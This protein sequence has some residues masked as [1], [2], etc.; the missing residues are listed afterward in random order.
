MLDLSL[1]LPSLLPDR[2][3]R[4]PRWEYKCEFRE[5]ES[6][7]VGRD[8]WKLERRQHFEEQGS[9][10]RDAFRRGDWAEALRLLEARGAALR[11][12]VEGE[13]RRRSFFHRVRVVEEP[14]TPYLQWELHSQRQ[15]AEYGERIHVVDAAHVRAAE[16]AAPLPEVV[17]LGGS[18]LYTVVYSASGAPEGAVR[19]TDPALVRP[20]EVFLRRLYAEGEDVRSYFDRKVASL[21]PPVAREQTISAE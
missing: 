5:R 4:L 11:A 15:R 1:S 20:W 8:S 19:F 13:R 12:S 16:T 3:V 14:L 2:G 18:H 17:I 21:R 6:A 10:S 9:P 7:L